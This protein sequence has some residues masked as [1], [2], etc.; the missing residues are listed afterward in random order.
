MSKLNDNKTTVEQPSTQ[1]NQMTQVE[2]IQVVINQP[3]Q[4]TDDSKCYHS[5]C[6]VGCAVCLII[7]N[8]P[9]CCYFACIPVTHACHAHTLTCTVPT[10]LRLVWCV[11]TIVFDFILAQQSL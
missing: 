3:K 9:A 2:M 1:I 10:T 11:P 4:S 5:D 7:I 6:F 8:N